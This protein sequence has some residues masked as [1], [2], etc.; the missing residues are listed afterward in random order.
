[1]SRSHH[2]KCARRRVRL[3]CLSQG[4]TFQGKKRNL[5]NWCCPSA[6]QKTWVD[7]R[8]QGGTLLPHSSR[9]S[10]PTPEP[11][12]CLCWSVVPLHCPCVLSLRSTSSSYL[13]ICM[14]VCGLAKKTNS[15]FLRINVCTVPHNELTMNTV[16]IPASHPLFS[17]STVCLSWI[18]RLLNVT[19]CMF[20]YQS[21]D[22]TAKEY[23]WRI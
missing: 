3:L 13:P 5:L 16:C 9:L 6:T 23:R 11:G 22:Y 7:L 18:K 15:K 17:G 2:S 14:P 21:S 12:Y 8:Q 4:T 20:G 1:M 19:E 10:G